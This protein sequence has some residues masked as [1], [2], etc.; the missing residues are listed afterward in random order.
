MTPI[1]ISRSVSNMGSEALAEK[2]TYL[3]Y[4]FCVNADFTKI[5]AVDELVNRLEMCV[6]E[7]LLRV[8]E[9]ELC[10]RP[11]Q[12]KIYEQTEKI[13]DEQDAYNINRM[14]SSLRRAKLIPIDPTNEKY[15]LWMKN[16]IK[17]GVKTIAE[18]LK[19]EAEIYI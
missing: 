3:S 15:I 7:S 1:E 18:C 19:E 14:M 4:Q 2:I 11:Y 5:E 8:F 9:Y 13:F 16:R 6:I 17:Y 10:Y 12:N